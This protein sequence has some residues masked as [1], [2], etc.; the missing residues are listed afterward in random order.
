MKANKFLAYMTVTC[1]SSNKPSTSSV[2]DSSGSMVLSEHHEYS[3]CIPL[4]TYLRLFV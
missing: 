3:K 1:K 4:Y 2:N